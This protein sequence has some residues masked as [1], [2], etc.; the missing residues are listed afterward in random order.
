M[1]NI[2][3]LAQLFVE[4]NIYP[5]SCYKP[6]STAII[7]QNKFPD[8]HYSKHLKVFLSHQECKSTQRGADLPWWGKKFFTEERGSKKV[9]V[10]SQDT[11]VKDAGSI[12]LATCLFPYVSNPNNEHADLV[13]KFYNSNYYKIKKQFTDGYTTKK[14]DFQEGWGLNIDFLY[15][16]DARKVYEENSWADRD[17]DEKKSKELLES[18]IDFCKPDLLIILGAP[19]V[20]LL[21]GK[22]RY[23]NMIEEMCENKEYINIENINV[24]KCVIVPFFVGSGPGGNERC[25]IKYGFKER[26]ETATKLIRDLVL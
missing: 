1:E 10:I 13:D 15:I 2:N 8:N 16:T 18:E 14:G 5:Q 4:Y 17:F 19:G 7:F 6:N 26:L 23:N 11:A 3:E 25:K 12:T 20:D 9:M 22:G 24:K 21:L